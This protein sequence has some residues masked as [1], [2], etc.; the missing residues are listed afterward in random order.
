MVATGDTPQTTLGIVDRNGV[1]RRLNVPQA[2]Y[3]SPRVSP[4]GR[5]IAVESIAE[6]GQSIISI[7]DLSG[8]TT[9][10]RLTNE[11]SNTRPVW[12][13]DSKRIVYGSD[14]EKTHGLYWQ[15]ADGTGLPERLTTAEEGTM[16]FPESWAPDGKVLSFAV[17]RSSLGQNSWGLWTLNVD[18]AEKKPTL[19]YDVP[20]ANEFGGNFSPDGK[21][22]AYASNNANEA[23]TT[24]GIYVQPYPPTG[25]RYEIS[26]NGGAWPVWHP[27]GNELFYR[28]NVGQANAATIKAVAITTNPVPGFTSDK[29]LPIQGFVL[30]T[31]Y[32]EYDVMPN[33]KEFVAVFPV[34]QTPAAAPVR[35]RINVVLNWFEE[36]K[37]RVPVQ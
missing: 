22:I 25:N 32:R 16:H 4:D 18:A 37:A 23:N 12:T 29:D 9:I 19:F 7:Y 30:A 26:R 34:V 31:N 8:T 17:V 5:S 36:L 24:F 14:R 21:W 2:V 1:V 13:R 27:L 35:P 11:G 10:R 33:G 28:L 6:N 3:R 15:L 20:G